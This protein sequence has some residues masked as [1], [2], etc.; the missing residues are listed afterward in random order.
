MFDYRCKD[1]VICWNK[2]NKAS[3]FFIFFKFFLALP[4]LSPMQDTV[5]IAPTNLQTLET[6]P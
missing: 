4:Q 5:P 6:L 2:K 3:F 1:T